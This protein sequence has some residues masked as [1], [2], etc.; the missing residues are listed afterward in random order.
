MDTSVYGR[1]MAMSLS[2]PDIP[3]LQTISIET[4]LLSYSDTSDDYVMSVLSSLIEFNFP[5]SVRERAF[6]CLA[7]RGI[8]SKSHVD[9]LAA[10]LFHIDLRNTD[11]S[12]ATNDLFDDIWSLG[13]AIESIDLSGADISACIFRMFFKAHVCRPSSLDRV[14]RLC[15]SNSDGLTDYVVSIISESFPCL[16][17]LELSNCK[18]LTPVSLCAIASASYKESL[19]RLDVSHNEASATSLLQLSS[20]PVLQ[21]LNLSF[22]C[23]VHEFS[24][25]LQSRNLKSLDLSALHGLDDQAIEDMLLGTHILTFLTE[26]RLTESSVSSACF[27]NIFSSSC[28]E[29]GGG[30]LPLELLDIS[31]CENIEATDISKVVRLCPLLRSLLLR[32]S[33]ADADTVLTVAA[34]CPSLTELQVSRCDDISDI[35]L[36]ELCTLKGLQSL[37]VS[38]ASIQNQST[39]SFLW[40]CQTLRVLS[41]QGCKGLGVDVVDALIQGAAPQLKF[42]D[43]G[44]VNMF[45][46]TLA[47]TLSG[48]RRDLIVVDYYMQVYIGGVI[49]ADRI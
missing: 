33:R 14:I 37:D 25:P 12:N 30:R 9:L 39:V 23:G 34:S 13:R 15:F 6:L 19:T 46:S 41:L 5:L 28:S 47:E 26:L 27:R 24:L 16:T 3:S 42:L 17:T 8:I 20:L 44:W 43:L 22:L 38:W 21:W 45:S 29:D 31:W 11:L 7:R 18:L 35:C 32:S 36:Q 48:T 10:H 40:S 1:E 4:A 2:S 49:V